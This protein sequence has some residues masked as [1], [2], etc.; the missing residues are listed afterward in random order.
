M[1]TDIGALRLQDLDFME[2]AIQL[3]RLG[4]SAGEVPIGALIVDESG[5]I[6]STAT[7]LREKNLTVIGHAEIIALHRA[8]K[9]MK[10]WRL[11]NCTLY[12]TLEPCFMCA[13]ALVQARIKRVVFGA[14]D[15]KGGALGSLTNLADDQRLNHQFNVLGGVKS[16]ECGHLLK[17][18]FKKKRISKK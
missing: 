2:K 7:N 5:K 11:T 18:F 13:G 17:T 12:V 1:N 3:A 4:E 6:I 15:P 9:K 10:S 16:E 8:C 14:Y